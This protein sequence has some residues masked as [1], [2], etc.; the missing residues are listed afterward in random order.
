MHEIVTLIYMTTEDQ[1]RE[2]WPETLPVTAI[3]A[4]GTHREPSRLSVVDGAARHWQE[5][6]CECVARDNSGRADRGGDDA[7]RIL[8]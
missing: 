8:A 4:G 7:M 2:P 3:V 5:R 1:R 6:T